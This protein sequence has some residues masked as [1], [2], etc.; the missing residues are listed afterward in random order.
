MKGLMR[1]QILDAD[2]MKLQTVEVPEWG[3]TVFVRVMSGAARD[4]WEVDTFISNG[5]DELANRHNIRARMVSRAACDE[6]GVRLF[7]DADVEELGKKSSIALDR[8]YA[9]AF[10]INKLN[11]E[12]IEELEKN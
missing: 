11:R 4:S 3:G 12:D 7:S 2:D 1:D 6:D 5:D 10:A 9:A 8:V